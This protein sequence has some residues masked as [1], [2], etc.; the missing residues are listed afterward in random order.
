MRNLLPCFWR[1]AR[2]GSIAA[3][4][5]LMCGCQGSVAPMPPEDPRGPVSSS[6]STPATSS[7]R[8]N[9]AKVNPVRATPWSI[10]YSDGSGNGYRFWQRSGASPAQYSYD[11]VQPAFSSSGTYSGGS[12]QKG[13][14]KEEQVAELWQ[15]VSVLEVETTRQLQAREK[16]TGSF[17]LQTPQEG[18]R[19]FFIRRGDT[20]LRE[21]HGFVAPF[22]SGSSL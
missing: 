7:V 16:G 19:S 1:A 11:P 5:W 10:H 6:T 20:L 9:P 17:R 4:V 22:R 13:E 8:S 12:P 15:R 3:L 18:K 21:F 2:F 14:L